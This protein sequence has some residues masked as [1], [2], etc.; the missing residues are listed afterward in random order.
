MIW[1]SGMRS[2]LILLK[3]KVLRMMKSKTLTSAP[4]LMAT[5]KQRRLDSAIAA[6]Q[7]RY[8][9]RSLKEAGDLALQCL[10]PHIASGSSSLDAL[11]GCGG[12][13]LSTSVLLTGQMTSGKLTVAYRTLALAQVPFLGWPVPRTA[14]GRV[15]L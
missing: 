15:W 6:I 2:P 8:G 12:F 5:P 13:P 7:A 14:R 4:R 9:E 11:T 3:P 1:D 10:S